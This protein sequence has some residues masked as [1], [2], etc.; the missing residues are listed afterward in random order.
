MRLSLVAVGCFFLLGSITIDVYEWSGINK[1]ITR[2]IGAWSVINSMC[3][4][5]FRTL[6]FSMERPLYILIQDAYF[7]C[8]FYVLVIC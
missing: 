6:K 7:T 2:C 4:I 3:G 1:T 8:N 5:A